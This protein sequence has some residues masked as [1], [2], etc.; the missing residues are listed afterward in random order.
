MTR[1]FRLTPEAVDVNQQEASI[2]TLQSNRKRLPKNISDY[3][4][5]A[6]SG[7]LT[8]AGQSGSLTPF[9]AKCG[10]KGTNK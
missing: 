6:L 5:C 4:V 1:H 3:V 7:L 10:C 9:H 8:A 2:L